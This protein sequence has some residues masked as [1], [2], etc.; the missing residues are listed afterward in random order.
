[1]IARLRRR[2]MNQEEDH[3]GMPPP[4]QSPPDAAEEATVPSD[5]ASP[6][7]ADRPLLAYDLKL[8]R[9]DIVRTGVLALLAFLVEILL[10]LKFE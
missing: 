1:M 3:F 8:L 6:R 7:H 2:L 10:Y 9:K 4:P 5:A